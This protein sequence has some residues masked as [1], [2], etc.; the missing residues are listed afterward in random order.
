M[1]QVLC[2]ITE[3]GP[4][5]G[6]EIFVDGPEGR[7]CIALFRAGETVVAYRNA[8]PHMGRSLSLAPGEFIFGNNGELVCPHHGACFDPATGECISGPCD[9]DYLRPVGIELQGNRVVLR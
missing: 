6:K 1:G 9:G 3:I 7:I 2:R 4:E 5:T 8:C